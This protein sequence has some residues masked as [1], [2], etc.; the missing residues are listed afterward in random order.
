LALWGIGRVDG[1]QGRWSRGDPFRTDGDLPSPT[2]FHT[3]AV[4]QS[5]V[6]ACGKPR[7]KNGQL[8]HMPNIYV[9]ISSLELVLTLQN[10]EHGYF[11][12]FKKV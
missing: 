5:S 4:G 6:I 8:A 12:F 11:S 10:V 1:A 7:K 2:Q 9:L 3:R